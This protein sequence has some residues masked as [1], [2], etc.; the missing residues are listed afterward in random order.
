MAL[1]LSTGLM[2]RRPDV[3]RNAAFLFSNDEAANLFVADR[4]HRGQLLYSEVAFQYGP[5][6]I[7]LYTRISAAL[8]NTPTVFLITMAVLSAISVGLVAWLIRRS[9]DAATALACVVVG[10]L[11]TMPLPGASVGGYAS[12][13]YM[14]LERLLLIAGVIL[15]MSPAPRPWWRS[16]AIGAVLGLCQGIRF[17]SG[18]VMLASIVLIDLGAWALTVK[19]ASARALRA[20]ALV[21]AGFFIVEGMWALWAWHALPRSFALEFLWPLHM[22]ETHRDT[23]AP[24]WPSVIGWHAAATQ[25]LMP[26]LGAALGFAGL[27]RWVRIPAAARTREWN[28]QGSALALLVFFLLASLFYFRHEHHFRQFAWTLVPAAAAVV[29]SFDR[30]RRLALLVMCLPAVWPVASALARRPSPDVVRLDVPRGYSMFVPP[31]VAERVAFLERYRGIG[32]VMFVPDGAGWL[33]AYGIDH[34]TRHVLFYSRAVVRPFE[35][36]R[37]VRD[38]AR[39]AAVIRCEDASRPWP[40]PVSAVAMIT[41]RFRPA[42]SGAGCT[43]WMP[44]RTTD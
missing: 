38:A 39:A 19:P 35:E 40:L 15:W 13:I 16:V 21:A 1:A 28:A 42:A 31:T 25:Y 9:A 43:V 24:R 37:F 34:V 6:S 22:L 17:G 33:Y 7:E 2:L 3:T 11:P 27:A 32:P 20:S 5:V 26:L 8:G 23:G 4:R 12:S 14:P 18:A 30:P 41:E 10:L 36:E 29:A 44:S